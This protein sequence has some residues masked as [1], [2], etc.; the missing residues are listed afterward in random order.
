MQAGDI[1]FAVPDSLVVTL[2]RVLGNETIGNVLSWFLQVHY[3]FDNCELIVILL[4]NFILENK[5][6]INV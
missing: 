5:S 2:E 3:P 6:R 4:V 1:A